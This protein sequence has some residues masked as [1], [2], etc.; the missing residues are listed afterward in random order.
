MVNQIQ[1]FQK[2]Y[3]ETKEPALQATIQYQ[4]E[5]L[6][7]Q[8]N[9]INKNSI[10][11]QTTNQNEGNLLTNKQVSSQENKI[12]QNENM[13]QVRIDSENFAKQIE[14]VKNNTFPKKDMLI[15]GKTPQVLKDI[16]LSDLPITMT[17]K[18][19]DTIMN[20]TGKYKNANSQNVQLLMSLK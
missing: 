15:L 11:E 9:N 8:L 17:Q 16:G 5:S 14:A 3:S 6:Q 7:E 20:E 19:L 2:I 12:A 4:I 10:I 1:E 13:E 18:H